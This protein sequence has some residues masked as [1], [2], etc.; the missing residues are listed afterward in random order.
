MSIYLTLHGCKRMRVLSYQPDNARALHV[1]FEGDDAKLEA[2]FFD[3]PIPTV[4]AIMA[5][6]GDYRTKQIDG[7]GAEIKITTPL[8]N[9][10]SGV[11]EET[12]F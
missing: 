6:F 11:S 3:L 9:Q 4:T 12:P 2:T 8:A 1:L 7:L 10:H 5:L